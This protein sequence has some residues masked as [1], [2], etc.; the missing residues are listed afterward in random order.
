ML[1]SWSIFPFPIQKYALFQ[2][3]FIQDPL[4]LI[5]LA[6][7]FSSTAKVSLPKAAGHVS[8]WSYLP[9]PSHPSSLYQLLGF[10]WQA[11][12]TPCSPQPSANT[13]S[14]E[15]RATG[16][17]VP[18]AKRDDGLYF[19]EQVRWLYQSRPMP[20]LSQ[21]TASILFRWPHGRAE[22]FSASWLINLHVAGHDGEGICHALLFGKQLAEFQLL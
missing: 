8:W 4:L 13:C 15:E 12:C 5:V 9:L 6:A 19:P 22:L 16:I 3:Q 10:S 21:Q 17:V 20:L 11:L 2:L 7:V 14:Q 18:V 1:F